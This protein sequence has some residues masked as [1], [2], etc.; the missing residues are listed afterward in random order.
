M[1]RHH[2]L[3]IERVARLRVAVEAAHRLATHTANSGVDVRQGLI[4]Q[5]AADLAATLR[6]D[7]NAIAERDAPV[8]TTTV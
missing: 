2:E 6:R 4:E 7:D 3:T 1:D 8:S 5:I